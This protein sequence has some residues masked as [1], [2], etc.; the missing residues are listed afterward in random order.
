MVGVGC[1]CV[2]VCLRGGWGVCLCVLLLLYQGEVN[3]NVNLCVHIPIR[4]LQA[5]LCIRIF[6]SGS[7]INYGSDSGFESGSKLSSASN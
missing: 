6:G 1:A 2:C 3:F 7:V 5:V 4:S